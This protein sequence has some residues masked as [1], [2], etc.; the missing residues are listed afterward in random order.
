MWQPGWEESLG[1]NGCMGMDG[2]VPSLFPRNSQHY[3]IGYTPIQNEKSEVCDYKKKE[4]FQRLE[5]KNQVLF[6]L[7]SF[8]KNFSDIL[9]RIH[10]LMLP[11]KFRN[12]VS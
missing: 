9:V 1:E 5:N 3:L 7:I 6:S 10:S 8:L 11:Y 2:W 4:I 12:S